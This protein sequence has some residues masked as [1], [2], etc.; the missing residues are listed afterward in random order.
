MARNDKI[1]LA[2]EIYMAIENNRIDEE[3]YIFTSQT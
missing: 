3:D 1:L 2:S